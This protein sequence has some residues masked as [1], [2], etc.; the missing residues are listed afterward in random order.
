MNLTK[1]QILEYLESLDGAKMVLDV[2]QSF[3]KEL[4]EE[5]LARRKRTSVQEELD[6]LSFKKY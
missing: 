1:K 3:M 5:V 4:C 2:E 6:D